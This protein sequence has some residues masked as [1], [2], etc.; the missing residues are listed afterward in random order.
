ML[1]A[2]WLPDECPGV[3]ALD[4]LHHDLYDT[5]HKLSSACDHEFGN[6]YC[7]LVRQVE[8]AFQK[9]ERWMEEMDFQSLKVHRE[10]HARV[11]GALHN[12]NFLVM[13][14]ELGV[15]RE[16]VQELLPQWLAFHISTMD[17]TLAR[18]MQTMSARTSGL[19]APGATAGEKLAGEKLES[20]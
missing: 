2:T 14:G 12:V 15:G 18:S 6:G 7:A 17:A 4:R 10:Q 11:L 9:E 20:H 3:L 1:H 16:V 5:L 19:S 13:N 8:Q